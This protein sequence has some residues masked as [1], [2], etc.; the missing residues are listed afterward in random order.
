MK[1]LRDAPPS[2]SRHART[3][4]RRR[5][6]VGK[7]VLELDGVLQERHR[8]VPAIGFSR[9]SRLEDRSRRSAA[10]SARVRNRAMTNAIPSEYSDCTMKPLSIA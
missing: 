5:L 7:R 1:S 10:I 3:D 2:R 4:T 6:C 8:F 9:D